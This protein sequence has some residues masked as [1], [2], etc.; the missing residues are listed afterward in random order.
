MVGLPY[1]CSFLGGLRVIFVLTSVQ[2]ALGIPEFRKKISTLSF[3]IS[4]LMVV[5]LPYAYSF[6]CGLRVIFAPILDKIALCVPEFKDVFSLLYNSAPNE[7]R[8]MLCL[9]SSL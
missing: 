2:I 9:Q 6:L 1:A 5:G 4:L 3:I 7:A 8:I